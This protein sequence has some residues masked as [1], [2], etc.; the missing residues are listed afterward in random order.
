MRPHTRTALERGRL[1]ANASRPL[2]FDGFF[3]RVIAPNYNASRQLLLIILVTK[4]YQPFANLEKSRESA[5]ERRDKAVPL[6]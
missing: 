2:S 5:L 3:R 6:S 1:L 4:F